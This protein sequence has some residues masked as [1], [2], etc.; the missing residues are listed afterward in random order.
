MSVWVKSRKHVGQEQEATWR[1]FCLTNL[2]FLTRPFDHLSNPSAMLLPWF[3]PLWYFCHLVPFCLCLLVALQLIP[4]WK[5]LNTEEK[6]GAIP[7][8][9]GVRALLAGCYHSKCWSSPPFCVCRLGGQAS[10]G[11]R[12]KHRHPPLG[13]GRNISQSGIHYSVFC[14]DPKSFRD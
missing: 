4:Y 13:R 8:T 12:G 9:G 2:F 10:Q 5:L 6:V 1:Q 14:T 3:C 7:T 11:W